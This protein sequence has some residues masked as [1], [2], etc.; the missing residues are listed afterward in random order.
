MHN[1]QIPFECGDNIDDFDEKN[2][3][4]N[5]KKFNII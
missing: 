1:G 4:N 3:L 5:Y 2:F